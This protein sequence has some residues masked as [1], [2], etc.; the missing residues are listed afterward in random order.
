MNFKT[1]KKG[2]IALA[3][4][5]F[6]IMPMLGAVNLV[7]A[8]AA[9]GV[10]SAVQSGTG[11]TTNVNSITVPSSPNPIGS[12]V[13]IDLYISGASNVW[14]WTIGSI[15]WNPAVLNLNPLTATPSGITEGP[16]LKTG[17][18]TLFLAGSINN[19][20]GDVAG[21]ITDA[22]STSGTAVA[23]TSAGVLVTLAFTVV[24]SGTSSV[25][26]GSATL[27]ASSSDTTGTT[28]T[29][30]SASVTVTAP[31]L[32]ISL[33]PHGQT[34]GNTITLPSSQNPIG[35]TFQVDAYITSA[36]PGTIWGWDF[37]VSWNPSVLEMVGTPTEGS[38]LDGGTIGVTEFAAGYPNNALGLVQGGISDAYNTLTTSSASSGVLA[39]LTF[40]II[41]YGSC[42]IVLSAGT[43]A[44]L[45]K[46]VIPPTPTSSQPILNNLAYS[47]TPA[48]ATSPQAV[49]T[50]N[51]PVGNTV[52]YTLY[53]T[54]LSGASSVPGTNTEPPSQTCP[55]T[56]YSWSI[57]L[58][59]A[60]TPI[61]FTTQ[62]VALTAAQIGDTPGTITATLTVTAPS[63]TNTPAPSYVDTSTPTTLSIIVE[64]P[65]SLIDVWTQNGGQGPYADA[66]SFGPQQLVDLYA[67]VT[68]NGAPVVDKTVTFDVYLDGQYLTYVTAPTDQ[69][70]IAT[71]SYRLP[72]QNTDPTQYFGE[73]TVNASV[74][75]AQDIL[76]DSC[77]FYYGYQL[78]L[79]SVVITNGGTGGTPTFNRYGMGTNTV[80]AIVTVTNTEWNSVPFYLAAT[81]FDNNS[82][83]VAQY[84]I[85]E[86]AP[87]AASGLWS[88]TNTQTYAI[89][90]TIPAWAY[91]GDATLYVNIF[92]GNPQ[93]GGVAFSPQVPAPLYIS[94]GYASDVTTIPI[95]TQVLNIQYN[96]QNDED[97]GIN[98]YWAM[99][100]YVETVQVWQLTAN[101]YEAVVVDQGTFTTYTGALSPQAG[102]PEQ[103]G[104]SGA[105][106]TMYGEYVATFT[107]TSF[108]PNNLPVYGNLGTKNYGGT[109]SDILL[110]LY[111]NG[112][113]GDAN[114]FDPITT[115]FAGIPSSGTGSLNYVSWGWTYTYSSGTTTQVWNNNNA[116]NS[117]DIVVS[118]Q[119][120]V[121]SIQYTVQ[122][123]EDTGLIGYWALDNYVKTVQVWSLGSDQYEAI[124]T[125]SGTFTTYAG[126]KSPQNGVT[127]PTTETGTMYGEYVATFTATS[128]NPS[129]L[130]KS[131]NIGTYNFGGTQNDILLGTYSKQTG[132]PASDVY[133]WLS[134]YFAGVPSSGA[135]SFNDV[136][137]GWSYTITSGTSLVWNNNAVG[138]T[139][140]IVT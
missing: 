36:A 54:T 66:S 35:S 60:T 117:G 103:T 129:N 75:V 62:T 106:G 83:P 33:V 139:G 71:T 19:A 10:I 115:Y 87:A 32:S 74:D 102:V 28:P 57:M 16:W 133:D 123:D 67:Y 91:V 26:I 34:S 140:D 47:W 56:T 136:S 109:K 98:G 100:N 39:T 125:Y 113:K 111:T 99:D 63:P 48:T 118:T 58:V 138:N 126:A 1:H 30:N 24:G 11:G 101:S 14:G 137:W 65:T 43:P 6:M 25:T 92:D 88:N 114:K 94:A 121:L 5:F 4:I 21:G 37:G 120:L 18:A 31:P 82:V 13:S 29:T 135:G 79:N 108:N 72:W 15:T 64:T 49:I 2:L 17:G 78:N 81:I 130:V 127:E 134:A 85:P 96:V 42:N 116:Q 9:T 131:G 38:Y 77:S 95:P 3:L 122:N 107:A 8:S 46:A 89:S 23:T 61:T 27:Y 105:T 97:T 73:M 55:I 104:S 124:S 93:S 86:T 84:L 76:T 22:I 50:T 69:S 52:T 128:F 90:L 41:S 53:P 20:V 132:D 68:Y 45:L 112:Q 59:G 119:P 80:N 12:T 70:G 40:Q 44:T 110:G 51:S 7:H